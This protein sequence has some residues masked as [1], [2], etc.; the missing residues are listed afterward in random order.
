[1][2]S[3]INE[4]NTEYKKEINSQRGF[5]ESIIEN[6]KTKIRLKGKLLISKKENEKNSTK[7]NESISTLSESIKK[8]NICFHI[9]EKCYSI[10]LLKLL[11]ILILI[12]SI[13]FLTVFSYD[14][15]KKR[16]KNKN[17]FYILISQIIIGSIKFFF[18][19]IN[20]LILKTHYSNNILLLI[21][22]ILII[23]YIIP[24]ILTFR[25][26]NWK[27]LIINCSYWFIL[28]VNSIISICVINCE[29]KRKKNVMHNIEEIINFT[30]LNKQKKQNQNEKYIFK[31]MDNKTKMKL[32][33]E[34][35]TDNVNSSRQVNPQ[36]KK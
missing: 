15:L 26:K 24:I 13:L 2:N 18:Y 4:K 8:K 31:N 28:F 22:H 30:E 7:L 17:N 29:I 20:I 12:I 16:I 3:E 9:I 19:F 14:I 33:E 10:S 6:N 1:M 34:N 27:Y 35:M 36:E 23:I 32:E 21:L 11:D 5:S 25:K